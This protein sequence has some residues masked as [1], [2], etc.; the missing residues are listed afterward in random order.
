MRLS[1]KIFYNFNL[2]PG[3]EHLVGEILFPY[4]IEF[5]IDN[6]VLLFGR[7]SVGLL[8]R[9]IFLASNP[10]SPTLLFK[11]GAF[12]ESHHSSKIIVGGEHNNLLSFNHSVGVYGK[13]LTSQLD[14]SDK[15]L[16]EIKTSGVILG[17]GV[18]ISANCCVLDAADI[19]DGTLLAAGAVVE[20]RTQAFSIYGGVPAK[21]IKKRLND[22]QIEII[23]S[24]QIER[25]RG[26]LVGLIP[27]IVNEIELGNVSIN[28]AKRSLE[29][30][31]I[32]PRLIIRGSRGT[33]DEIIVGEIEN[34]M[35]GDS[36]ITDQS[37][38]NQLNQYFDQCRR[39]ASSLAWSPDVFHTLNIS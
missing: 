26:H 33:N 15:N 14:E 27:S 17:N 6:S 30:M 36:Y 34:Y 20:K 9:I 16:L 19:G 2:G 31:E 25:I 29:Y 1:G 28:A 22:I 5:K 32:I 37:Q 35:L 11:S 7:Y 12:C 21:F 18:I 10:K 4:E 39:N 3:T 23:R 24:L 8:K 38:I 13:L